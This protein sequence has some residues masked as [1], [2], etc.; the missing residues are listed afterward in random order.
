MAVDKDRVKDPVSVAF[1]DE[2]VVEGVCRM[3]RQREKRIK[4]NT[5]SFEI[6]SFFFVAFI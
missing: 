6:I 3:R 4:K 1:E 2:K 5:W